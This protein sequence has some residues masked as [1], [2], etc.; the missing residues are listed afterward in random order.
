MNS[1]HVSEIQRHRTAIGRAGLSRPVRLAL[2]SGLI[3]PDRTVFDYGCGRGQDIHRLGQFGIES[4]GWDPL[5]RPDAPQTSAD[6]VN[7]GYVVNVIENP[8]ERHETLERAWSLSRRLLVVAAR[9][10]IEKK[11]LEAEAYADGLRTSRDT[12]QKLY[13]QQ[14]LRDWVAGVT[15][16]TPV[17]AAPGVLF[18]FRDEADR[19]AYLASRYLRRRGA[20]KVRKA[21]KVYEQHRATL[22]PLIEFL[23]ERGRLPRRHELANAEELER[24]VG[25]IRQ[26]YAILRRVLGDD[27]WSEVREERV[28][29]LLIYLALEKFS[30]R[31]K[32][33]DLPEVLQL[34]IKEFFSSYRSACE[35]ADELLFA[36]GDQEQ[37]EQA[38]QESKVGKFTGNA[39]YVHVD[40]LPDL[41][42][43][44]RVYEGCARQYVGDLE[45][46]NIVKLHRHSPKVSYL[47]YPEFRKDPHPA[48]R[49]SLVVPLGNPNIRYKDYA[50][51]RNPFILH[52]KEDFVSAHDPEREKYEKLTRQEERWGLYA[53]PSR[54]GTKEGWEEMLA[55]RGVIHRGHQLRRSS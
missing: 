8:R 10:D 3:T 39:L 51:S 31:P 26:A 29:E 40:A 49:G 6:V 46:G 14:E 2:E 5:H 32:F 45:G 21:D 7:L 11:R 28:T 15:S 25:T 18:V 36:A 27:A 19:Q 4:S 16:T 12:F 54:I 20:P 41:P 23:T 38:M 30:G 43:I 13:A 34:D 22:E 24:D 55:V 44:V 52:R 35:Q 48:I 47:I 53:D 1:P 9:L 50:D 17:P 33:S 37:R 42:P